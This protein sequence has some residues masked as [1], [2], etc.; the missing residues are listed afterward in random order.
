MDDQIISTESMDDILKKYSGKNIYVSRKERERAKFQ[1]LWEGTPMAQPKVITEPVELTY[2]VAKAELWDIMKKNLGR[3]TFYIHPDNKDKLNNIIKAVV[4]DIT[5]VYNP[6][7][8]I[9]LYGMNS[10]GKSWIMERI[11]DLIHRAYYSRKYSNVVAAPYVLSYKKNIMMRAKKE[12]SIAFVGDVFKNKEI[13]Y[14]DDLGYENG[15]E[16]VLYGQR[17]NMIVEL[18]DILHGCYL[19]GAKV[20]FTSNVMPDSHIAENNTIMK[21]YGKGTHDRLLQM[22]TPVYWTGDKNLR[23]GQ[24]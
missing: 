20:Y 8:G 16:L 7:K 23:T 21:L 10:H 1:D 5:G 2:E 15:S 17:E 6:T 3:E 24:I 18:V 13:I 12:N 19:K 22:C 14:V 11:M 4:D 9:Y